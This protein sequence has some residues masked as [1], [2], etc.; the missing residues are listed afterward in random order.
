MGVTLGVVDLVTSFGSE[1]TGG[2][3]GEWRGQEVG[4]VVKEMRS[5]EEEAMME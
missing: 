3:E 1:G 4:A 2:G 5:E